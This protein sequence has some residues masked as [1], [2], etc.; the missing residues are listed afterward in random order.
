MLLTKI[1]DSKVVV[2][3]K[4]VDCAPGLFDGKLRYCHSIH[5]HI[6]HCF[7]WQTDG[8]E[9]FFTF[10]SNYLQGYAEKSKFSM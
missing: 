9:Y 5:C 8:I 2:S 6:L 4:K 3:V 7:H 1:P 10:R